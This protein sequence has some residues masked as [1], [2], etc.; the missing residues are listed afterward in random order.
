[1]NQHTPL[2]SIQDL[3][4]SPPIERGYHE[5]SQERALHLMAGPPDTPPSSLGFSIEGVTKRWYLLIAFALGY[6]WGHGW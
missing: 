3:Y 5:P 2:G 6:I 1:M 4:P